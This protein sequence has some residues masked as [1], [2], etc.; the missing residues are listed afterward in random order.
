MPMYILDTDQLQLGDII[1]S[2]DSGDLS[3]RVRRLSKSDYSHAALV[4]SLHSCVESRLDGVHSDN[5]Q[6]LGFEQADDALV[7]RLRE[8]ADLATLDR[9][10]NY[11]RDKVGTSYA[12]GQEVRQ[13]YGAGTAGAKETNRQFCTRLITQAYAAGGITLVPNPDYCTPADVQ[14]S[15][16]L[17]V[18]PDCLRVATDAE[19]QL[20]EEAGS[21]LPTEQAGI[22]GEFLRQVQHLTGHDLQT[23]TQLEQYLITDQTHDTAIAELFAASGY[24]EIGDRDKAQVPYFY[25]SAEFVKQGDEQWRYITAS[26]HVY[27]EEVLLRGYLA[28]AKRY[29][30]LAKAHKSRYFHLQATCMCRQSELSRQRYQV[31]ISA[32]DSYLPF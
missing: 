32:I 19:V 9:V 6:R 21:A 17:R 15:G 24:L 7:L 20:V 25:D 16:Q 27:Q 12:S 14:H 26:T 11:A 2:R 29:V 28:A 22:S 31:W 18:I 13:S 30:H 4:V 1:L 23:L 8:P 3:V 10:M 5:I